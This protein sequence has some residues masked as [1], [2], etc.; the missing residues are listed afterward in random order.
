MTVNALAFLL[1]IAASG[2][3]LVAGLCFGGEAPPSLR[4]IGFTGAAGGHARIGFSSQSNYYYLL[5]RA[6]SLEGPWEPVSMLPGTGKGLTLADPACMRGRAFYRVQAQSIQAPLDSDGDR[7]DDLTEFAAAGRGNP[8]NPAP[9]PP[10]GDAAVIL[11]SREMYEQYAHRDNFPGAPDVREVK[12]LIT[13]VDTASPKLYFLNTNKH[14]YHYYF[15][16]AVLGY[17]KDLGTFNNE[18]YFSD[19]RKFMAGSLIAY[20]HYG[21][22]GKPATGLYGMEFWPSDGVRAAHVRMAYNLISRALPWVTTRLAYHPAGITQEQVLKAEADVWRTLPVDLITSDELFANTSYSVLNPGVSFG[23]LV[24]GGGTQSVTARDV[25]VLPTVPADLSRVAGIITAS[26]QTPLSHINLKAKQNKTPNAYL[27]GAMTDTLIMTLAGK[28]VRLEVAADGLQLREATQEEVDTYLDALRPK[29]PQYP[30]RD[31]SVT[32]IRP[33]KN[34]PFTASSSVGAKAANAAELRRILPAGMSPDGF[35]IPFYFYDTFMKFN[36]FYD[37]AR[38]MM[39]DPVFQSDS[40]VREQRLAAFREIIKDGTVS[41]DLRNAMRAVQEQFAPGV[42]I[43]CRSSTNNEDLP[44]FNGAGLY[45]SNTHRPDEGSLHKSVRKVWASLWNFR[46]FEERNFY[47]IDHFTAAMGVLLIP[48][49]DDELANGVAV[50]K[51][52]IDPNWRGYYVNVQKGEELVTNPDGSLIPEEFLIA[53]LMGETPY[54]IQHVTWSS[55]QPAQ[56]SLLTT[57]QAYLLADQMGL[58][59][60]NFR[61]LYN[62]WANPDFAME[63]EFKITK[64]NKLFIKQARPWV[65]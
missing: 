61:S 25:V 31:L 39:A 9:P 21:P 7:V 41:D 59:Q 13:G 60:N 36:G 29:N 4:I 12:F 6:P 44:G 19:G 57:E 65:E 11:R 38:A 15:A 51:N 1:R 52:L 58:I 56:T 22:P 64:A 49:T 30:V 37:Q 53:W 20:D 23:R 50:T 14:I 5:Q 32:T 2:I 27:R 40:T 28:N 62:A 3:C 24:L 33:L 54:E 47:R 45:D 16:Q 43:R 8:F 18:T 55:L 46:A 63:I 35:A 17:S 26:P 42:P 34:V 10:A 48:N